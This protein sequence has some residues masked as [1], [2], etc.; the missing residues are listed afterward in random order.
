MPL[1]G[2]EDKVRDIFLIGCYTGQRFSDYHRI[3]ESNIGFTQNV[4]KVIRL[5]QQ[6]TKSP[7]VIPI[8]NDE[9]EVLLKKYNY[10][11]PTISE[12]KLN[13]Y[14]K[15]ICR[16]LSESVPSLRGIE[17]TLMTK[18][19]REL[20]QDKKRSYK[21]DGQEQ[22][23]KYRWEM[24]ASHTAR[25]TMVTNMY[26]PR[27]FSLQQIM[28]VSGHKKEETLKRYLKLALDEFADDVAREGSDGLF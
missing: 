1:E 3:D 2:T 17:R 14:I 9:L 16:R 19:E 28:S 4:T 6:K 23:I 7:V 22:V 15:E 24:V 8:L 21:H 13:D 10:C 11:V 25:R 18:T 27:K 12:Q 5:Y 20:E 26:L